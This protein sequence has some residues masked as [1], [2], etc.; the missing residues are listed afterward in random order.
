MCGATEHDLIATDLG[1]LR[2]FVPQG[3]TLV[4]EGQNHLQLMWAPEH[5]I[6][7]SGALACFGDGSV[8]N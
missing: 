1:F 2:I 4:R 7:V 8:N 5:M 3:Y 6:F